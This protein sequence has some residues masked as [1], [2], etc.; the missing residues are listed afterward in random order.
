MIQFILNN[1][2]VTA[3]V[4]AGMLLLD[5]IRYH[6]H[7]YG[8]KIGCREGD[9]GACTVLIGEIK[10]N[11][12]RYRT[13][14]SCLTP[15]GNIH[16]KHVATIEGINQA[17]LNPV[18]Q[19]MAD[20]SAT[21]CGFCTPGFILSLSGYCLS[22]T[23]P[24]NTN[25][26][27][28]IDGNICR[29]T[30]YKSIERAATHVTGILQQ[31]QLQNPVSYAVDN[32]LVPA[33]FS[34]IQQRLQA[35]AL[36]LNGEL[37]PNSTAAVVG[38][39]TDLYVQKHDEMKDASIR[40]MLPQEHLSIIR[41]ADENIV[42]GPSATVTDMQES[43]LIQRHFANFAAQAKLISSTPIRNM[44]TM[45]GNL[46]N[47]SPIGDFSIFFLALNAT[48]TLRN[49][50]NERKLLLRQLYKGYK[51]LDKQADEFVHEIS[52]PLP[53]NNHRFS[54]EKVSKRMHLDIASV[55]SAMAIT[56]VDG[57]IT[58]VGLSGGGLAPIPLFLE[59]TAAFLTG[60][61]ISKTVIENALEI[62]QT[63]IYP[64]SDARGT[65]YYKRLLFNQLLKA[66][67]LKFF[68]ATLLQQALHY[69]PPQLTS[70]HE[71]H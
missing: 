30:G 7:L 14:T 37:K 15:M 23:K 57:L 41:E 12:L 58:S 6:K 62:A 4:P 35:L 10:N 2:Q 27:A 39:G 43:P 71:K 65:A 42:I 63:E 34:D 53:H 26:L 60:K 38:G 20:C 24:N 32:Q 59:K 19:A 45:A 21:Q 68:G 52:F 69:L 9:C 49:A 61:V 25:A 31:R 48:I 33:Y 11:H 51:I 46:I 70:A 66:H 55:N 18:Q 67:F 36:Q 13:F 3:N 16:G 28:A 17:K 44:A 22:E 5:Y 40:F 64:I 8:T 1:K 56:E 47:A 50:G 54:F 29:C